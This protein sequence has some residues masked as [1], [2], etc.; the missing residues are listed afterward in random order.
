MDIP[1]FKPKTFDW[2]HGSGT[3][4]A[5]ATPT[6]LLTSS[7]GGDPGYGG[8]SSMGLISSRR[9]PGYG[10]LPAAEPVYGRSELTGHHQASRGSSLLERKA[11]SPHVR[12]EHIMGYRYCVPYATVP[13][14]GGSYLIS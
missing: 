3:S 13:R 8:G 14:Y 2:G 7:M 5:A 12:G 6:T 10:G 9:D 4:A 1:E 11:W